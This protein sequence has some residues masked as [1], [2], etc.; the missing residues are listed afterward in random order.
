[1]KSVGLQPAP[2]VKQQPLSHCEEVG[3]TGYTGDGSVLEEWENYGDTRSGEMLSTLPS[4]S[5]LP[6]EG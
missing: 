3:C 1:M 5:L 6:A 4:F 2:A